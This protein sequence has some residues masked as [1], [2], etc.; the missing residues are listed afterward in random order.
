MKNAYILFL[1]I[2]PACFLSCS[3][4]LPDGPAFS[5]RSKENR[6][7]GA[8]LVERVIENGDDRTFIYAGW[9]YIFQKDG[10]AEVIEPDG[11]GPTTQLF[12]SWQL[13]CNDT[14]DACFFTLELSGVRNGSPYSESR[15][16]QVQRLSNRRFWL[17]HVSSDELEQIEIRLQAF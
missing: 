14:E 6:I 9:R 5:L 16:Y 3:K 1:L 4:E 11:L 7:Q 13:D 2:L 17:F 12:G 8:W 15:S 10:V